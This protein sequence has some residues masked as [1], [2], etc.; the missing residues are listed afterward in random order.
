M[1]CSTGLT[2]VRTCPI[3]WIPNRPSK[4]PHK[5]SEQLVKDLISFKFFAKLSPRQDQPFYSFPSHCQL[6][7][8]APYRFALSSAIR[9]AT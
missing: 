1:S 4:S 3:S 5:L 6:L 8:S 9:L 2:F 7:F